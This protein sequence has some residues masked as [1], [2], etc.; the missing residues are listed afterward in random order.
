M[1]KKLRAGLHAIAE[2]V[3]P[4]MKVCR[5]VLG[6]AYEDAE[7]PPNPDGSEPWFRSMARAFLRA[8]TSAEREILELICDAAHVPMDRVI[9]WARHRYGVVH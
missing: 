5:A 2:A 9:T 3:T 8:D 1:P 6:Q 4:E 7:M